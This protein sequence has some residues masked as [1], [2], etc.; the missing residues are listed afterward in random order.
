L[1]LPSWPDPVSVPTCGS[2]C[3]PFWS[4]SPP[5]TWLSL[6]PK[7]CPLPTT[8]GDIDSESSG[9]GAELSSLPV[10]LL[11]SPL[12]LPSATISG[13]DCKDKAEWSNPSPPTLTTLPSRLFPIFDSPCF[14]FSRA[15]ER[16]FRKSMS[17]QG[18]AGAVGGEMMV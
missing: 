7:P 16:D 13:P 9:R 4:V 8:D 17:L 5:L 15:L 1:S 18:F 2:R 10:A 3:R 11:S 12:T 6:P 14:T